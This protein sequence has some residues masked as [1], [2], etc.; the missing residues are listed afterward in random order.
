M[1]IPKTLGGLARRLRRVAG[2]VG[3]CLLGLQASAQGIPHQTPFQDA[4]LTDR[5]LAAFGFVAVPNETASALN[6]SV[7]TGEDFDFRTTQLGGGFRPRPGGRLYLEGFLGWQLY[8]PALLRDADSTLDDSAET[9]AIINT[10]WSSRAATGAVGYNFDVTPQLTIRPLLHAAIGEVAPNGSLVPDIPLIEN[11]DGTAVDLGGGTLRTGGYGASIGLEYKIRTQPREV[12]VRA[13]YTWMRL[14][15]L[16]NDPRIDSEADAI[17]ASLYGRYRHPIR[18]WRALSRP[19]RAVWEASASAYPGDQGSSLDTPWLAQ[20]GAGLELEISALPIP[21]LDRVRLVGRYAV[22][23]NY[24]GYSIG[25]GVAF[26]R[27]R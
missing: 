15:A 1:L 20:V 10:R 5:A 18:S 19:V 16:E 14:V 27:T 4:L 9:I 8:D 26:R 25:L 2:H 11:D 12:D 7:A 24:D 17:A 13:R 3:L 22:G 21:Y 6:F 23:Q